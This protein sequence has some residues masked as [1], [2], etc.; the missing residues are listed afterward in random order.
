MSTIR[1]E[2]V[3]WALQKLELHG[4]GG[5]E[6]LGVYAN[7]LAKELRLETT[8][9]AKKPARFWTDSK[10]LEV[11]RVVANVFQD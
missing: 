2:V 3:E 7:K 10:T 4:V 9:P 8:S 11:L 6:D 5:L 1:S